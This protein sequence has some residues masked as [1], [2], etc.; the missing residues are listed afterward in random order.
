RK[1]P[2]RRRN[3]QTRSRGR[4]ARNAAVAQETLGTE[5][6]RRSRDSGPLG[7]TRWA[8]AVYQREWS[9]RNR[10]GRPCP[11]DGVPCLNSQVPVS[12]VLALLMTRARGLPTWWE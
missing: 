6:P 4:T 2:G 10:L 12:N 9:L 7:R 1:T 11:R 8:K 5:G 3:R